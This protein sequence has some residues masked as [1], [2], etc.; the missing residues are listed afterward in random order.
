MDEPTNALTNAVAIRIAFT[1]LL[2]QTNR[3]AGSEINVGN[4]LNTDISWL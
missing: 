1:S 3:T 2:D 4:F